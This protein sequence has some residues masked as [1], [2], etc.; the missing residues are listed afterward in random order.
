MQTLE[1]LFCNLWKNV[2]RISTSKSKNF[3]LDLCSSSLK[4]TVALI[5]TLFE[6]SKSRQNTLLIENKLTDL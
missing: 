3:I 4:S 1:K 2:A 5:P 6:C